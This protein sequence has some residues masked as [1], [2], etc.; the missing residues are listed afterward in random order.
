MGLVS[1]RLENIMK[2]KI[3][4]VNDRLRRLERAGLQNESQEYLVV[5][6]YAVKKQSPYYNVN[7]E[8]GTIRVS[9]D[10]SRFETASQIY[11]FHE[12]LNNIL[13]AKTSTV[14]GT[15]GAIKKAYNTFINSRTHKVQP[16]MSFEEYR[17]L[18]KI[19]RTNV[20]S[21]KKNHFGSNVMLDLIENTDIYTLT[22]DQ[23]QSAL[24]YASQY[25]VDELI[26]NYFVDTD[27]G[28]V[29]IT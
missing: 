9:T 2:K 17:N 8:N 10:F 27:E 14:R 18:F 26:D 5:E 16:K 25:G 28:L 12:V 1:E 3:R 19:Y 23:I 21:D 6:R 4:K 11:S 13:K 24:V 20:E 15:K 22:D 7:L 29:F